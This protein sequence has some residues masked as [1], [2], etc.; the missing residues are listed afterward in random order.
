MTDDART[1]LREE[2]QVFFD[3]HP[4]EATYKLSHDA[5]A[6][7]LAPPPAVDGCQ[8]E[9]WNQMHGYR[10]CADCD[11]M[12]AAAPTPP[13]AS[14]PDKAQEIID[15]AAKMLTPSDGEAVFYIRV[16]GE[17]T[18]FHVQT[19]GNIDPDK[20]LENAIAAINGERATLAN[21]PVHTAAPPHH[22]RQVRCLK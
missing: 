10:K 3:K 13:A 4:N 16:G 11:A 1:R 5:F 18:Q 9:A 8:H 19:K 12:L 14:P 2:C 21:C 22:R 7:L 17:Y 6:A 15:R 20:A